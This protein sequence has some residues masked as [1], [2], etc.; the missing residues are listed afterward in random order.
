MAQSQPSTSTAEEQQTPQFGKIMKKIK[1]EKRQK[2]HPGTRALKEIRK[3]QKTTELLIPKIAFLIVV[4]ELLQKESS[5]YRIQTDTVLALHKA[6]EAYLIRLFED[7]NLCA[8]HAKHVTI[9]PKD[10]TLARQISGKS[11]S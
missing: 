7:M 9:M 3:F 8:I 10:M 5:W 4:W 1:K 11:S 2:F 6:T